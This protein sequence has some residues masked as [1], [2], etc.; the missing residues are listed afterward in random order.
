MGE[1]D[2]NVI[3]ISATTSKSVI[4]GENSGGFEI[5]CDK[6]LALIYHIANNYASLTLSPWRQGPL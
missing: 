6:C 1:N 3:L 5:I 2:P 4:H